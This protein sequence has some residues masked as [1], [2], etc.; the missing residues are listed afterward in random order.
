MG[1]VSGQHRAALADRARVLVVDDDPAMRISTAAILSDDCTVKTAKSGME[2]LA[3]LTAQPFDV[4]CTDLNMPGVDGFELLRR[5]SEM[6]GHIGRVLVTGYKEYMDRAPNDRM[7]W[8][9]VIKPY[10]ADHLLQVVKRAWT[11]TRLRRMA[12]ETVKLTRE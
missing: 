12:S 4:L 10:D 2:A 3:M 7:A 6:P 1:S 5:V 8:F 11:A 9:V